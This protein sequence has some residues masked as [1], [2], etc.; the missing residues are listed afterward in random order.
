MYSRATMGLLF[1]LVGCMAATLIYVYP[2]WIEGF[3][4]SPWTGTLDRD[5]WIGSTFDAN[6]NRRIFD[7]VVGLEEGC[8]TD[9]R[10]VEKPFATCKDPYRCVNGFC[11]SDAPIPLPAITPL[12]IR[13]KRFTSDI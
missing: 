2:R 13:P 5:V 1:V 3:N 10:T 9:A 11:K 7:G 4:G 8:G 6:G 12:P